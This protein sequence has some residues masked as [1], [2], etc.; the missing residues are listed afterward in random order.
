MVREIETS[1]GKFIVVPIPG[2]LNSY[3]LGVAIMNKFGHGSYVTYNTT[4]DL[5]DQRIK[6]PFHKKGL[7]G[8]EI[9]GLT[10]EIKQ[11]EELAKKVVEHMNCDTIFGTDFYGNYQNDLS[12]WFNKATTSFTSLCE[13]Y[14]IKDSNLIIRKI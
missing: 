9:I 12:S 4:S 10:S 13:K 8:F 5:S 6:L 2:N 3:G 14:E 7:E 11:S 1:L